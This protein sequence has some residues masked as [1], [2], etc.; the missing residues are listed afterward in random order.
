[1]GL[2]GMEGIKFFF[3]NSGGDLNL[4]IAQKKHRHVSFVDQKDAPSSREKSTPPIG[5]MGEKM[6]T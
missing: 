3:R 5:K 4:T 2:G 1:M 6:E